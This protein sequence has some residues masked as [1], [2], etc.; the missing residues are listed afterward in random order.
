MLRY[1][2]ILLAAASLSLF[3]YAAPAAAQADCQTTEIDTGQGVVRQT[4]CRG[5]DGVWRPQ[6]AAPAA[7]GAGLAVGGGAFPPGWSGS[8]TYTGS[9]QGA[10]ETPGRP[11]RR[12][13]LDEAVRSATSGS[14][15]EI[16]GPYTLELTIEGNAVSGRLRASGGVRNAN[17]SGTRNGDRCRLFIGDV[18][19]E[20]ECTAARFDGRART[21]G[22]ERRIYNY[23]V[24]A[25]ATRVVDN[26]AEAARREQA[27]AEAEAR[28]AEQRAERERASQAEAARIAA[29]PRASQAQADTLERAVRQDS[30]AWAFNRYDIGSM[31]NV[32]VSSSAGGITTLRGEYT[33]NGGSRGWVEA[34]VSGGRVEC[35]GYWDMGG[36][37]AVRTGAS[38]GGGSGGGVPGTTVTISSHSW[39]QGYVS[40]DHGLWTAF[41]QVRDMGGGKLRFYEINMFSDSERPMISLIEVDCREFGHRTLEGAMYQGDRTQLYLDQEDYIVAQP[42]TV[43]RRIYQHMCTPS[44]W[45]RVADP[46]RTAHDWFGR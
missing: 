7:P 14:R 41:T 31:S 43:G 10:I 11:M 23:R 9:Y 13:T 30:S 45:Q 36:C 35:L 5:A 1:S 6:Q 32:R 22:N 2:L 24:D 28:Q 12:F 15:E 4:M 19:V 38:S 40:R 37:S 44:Q 26:R 46:V 16:G 8:V 27:A 39:Q 25:E 18:L 42:G 21:Q 17:V 34:R 29:L 20:A 33:Y 3:A